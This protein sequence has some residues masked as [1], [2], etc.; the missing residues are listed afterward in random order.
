METEQEPIGTLDML[1][2]ANQ[3]VLEADKTLCCRP[4]TI[5]L[6]IIVDGIVQQY[7]MSADN[8]AEMKSWQDNFNTVLRALS[9]WNYLNC[10]LVN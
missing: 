7:Y 8:K 4:R 10:Y 1:N 6:E 5:Y 2:C 9:K 3:V